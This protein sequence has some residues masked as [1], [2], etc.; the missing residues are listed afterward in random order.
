[1]G[2]GVVLER[3]GS[4]RFRFGFRFVLNL[5]CDLGVVVVLVWVVGF[6][7]VWCMGW[8]RRFVLFL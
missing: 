2:E 1:M 3:M 5:F 6:L 7:L 8:I 4:G